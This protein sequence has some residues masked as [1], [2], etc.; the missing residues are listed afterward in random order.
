M[1]KKVKWGFISKKHLNYINSRCIFTYKLDQIIE[2]SYV[3]R[4]MCKDFN[5]A[6]RS[7]VKWYM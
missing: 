4:I 5:M 2:L 1:V 6:I 3:E 7:N